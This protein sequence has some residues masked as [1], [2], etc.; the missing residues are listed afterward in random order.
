M[1]KIKEDGES[2][3]KT[4][5]EIKVKHYSVFSNCIYWIKWIWHRD[6][7]VV[8]MSILQIIS[9]SLAP[10]IG[11]YLPKLTIDMITEGV[12]SER[13]IRNLGLFAIFV[14]LLYCL[15]ES[16]TNGKYWKYNF[17]R[18]SDLL[19][20][21][22]LKSTTVKYEITESGKGKT[23]YQEA[24][25]VANNGDWSAFSKTMDDVPS[26]LIEIICFALYSTV[27]GSLNLWMVFVLIGLSL[28]NCFWISINIKYKE[29]IR[30]EEAYADRQFYYVKSVM[31]DTKAAKDVRIFGMN[32]WLTG[33]RDNII[34]KTRKIHKKLQDR[35]AWQEKMS[36]LTQMVRDLMAYG[37]LIYMAAEGNVTPGEFVLYFGA[38]T[39]FSGFVSGIVNLVGDLRQARNSTNYFRAYMEL[40]DE[41]MSEGDIHICDM[42]GPYS[43]EFKDICFSYKESGDEVSAGDD[44]SSNEGVKNSDEACDH[45]KVIFD[46]FNLKIAAGER[47]ALVGVNGAGKTTLVKLL[48][49]MYEPDEGQILI[50]GIDIRRI[51]KR[52]MYDLFSVVFQEQFIMPFSIGEN[53][54]M[55]RPEHID[56]KRV[57]DAIERAGIKE[58]FEEKKITPDTFMTK[59]ILKSGISFSGG[60]QQRLLLARA[61]YKDGAVMILDEPTAALDPIAES[62]IYESY[63]KYTENKT[64]VF[65]SH[66]LASTRFS[67]RIVMIEN[68]KIVDEGTHEELM[69]KGGAYSKMYEIQGN[70]YN[71]RNYYNSQNNDNSQ[72]NESF[73]EST[74]GGV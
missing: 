49:G 18:G 35:N 1:K 56:E 46:H 34:E 26:L 74:E 14:I 23:A 30:E 61:L 9:N 72:G 59:Q 48:C 51:P 50:N 55:K 73:D 10:L 29:S 33:I 45:E 54:A 3:K 58:I 64:A 57:W 41:D 70:Y 42:E 13:L 32:G 53:I 27:L 38:I 36:F 71:S 2:L 5:N 66:R 17:R 47:I 20:E 12:T 8:Y 15:R 37:Y 44:V 4:M 62:E 60:Q 40:P 24:L 43:I 67:D 63:D 68:G 65:I 21:L 11:I 16:M 22:F 7:T 31:G 52:E 69:E 6:R 39:G 25:N 19:S 28:L